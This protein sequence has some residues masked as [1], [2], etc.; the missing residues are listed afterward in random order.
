[1]LRTTNNSSSAGIA[2]ALFVALAGLAGS[3]HGEQAETGTPLSDMVIDTESLTTIAASNDYQSRIDELLRLAEDWPQ[4][5]EGLPSEGDASPPYVNVPN[6]DSPSSLPTEW[7]DLIDSTFTPHTDD[8]EIEAEEINDSPDGKTNYRG[9]QPPAASVRYWD[10]FENI[11]RGP[12]W[13]DEFPLMNAGDLGNFGGP[14][15]NETL[16]LNVLMDR[17]DAGVLEFDLYVLSQSVA[18]NNPEI[19]IR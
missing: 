2:G 4:D 8:D 18:R 14:L 13:A 10:D 15:R 6:R 1:M 16:T 12:E 3:V 19:A 17:A 7:Q 11:T 5:G 9:Q